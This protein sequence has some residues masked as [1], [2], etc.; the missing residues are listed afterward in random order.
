MQLNPGFQNER[1]MFQLKETFCCI[2]SPCSAF[3]LST[4]Q[5]SHCLCKVY[6]LFDGSVLWIHT[7]TPMLGYLLERL[8]TRKSWEEGNL[9]SIHAVP[10]MGV[11]RRCVSHCSA[12]GAGWGSVV[13]QLSYPPHRIKGRASQVAQPSVC[14][15]RLSHGMTRGEM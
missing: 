6:T 9:P 13:L 2:T 12:A 1:L 11:W 15:C 4:L 10:K 3:G 14:W 5:G 7:V 8:Q